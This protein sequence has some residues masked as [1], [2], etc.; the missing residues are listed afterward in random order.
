MVQSLVIALLA[1]SSLSAYA[2]SSSSL[3]A[4]NLP[5]EPEPGQSRPIA[6]PK[7][8]ASN[9]DK[10]PIGAVVFGYIYLASETAPG[11]PWNFHLHGFYGIPQYNLKPW[12]AVFA[13]FTQNYNTSYGAHENVQAKLGGFLFTAK[14]KAKISPFGFADAGAIRDSKNGTVAESPGFAVGGGAT[15]KI[16]KHLAVLLI[17]GEYVRTYAAAG[18]L[19]NFTA[20]VGLVLPLYRSH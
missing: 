5:G 7:A 6:G 13:D 17:P 19:N 16:N 9:Q 2:Q 10:G 1:L 20:R 4:D 11:G 15:Y 18:D 3:I 8:P 14:A 12:L